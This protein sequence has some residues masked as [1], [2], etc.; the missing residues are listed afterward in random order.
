[1]NLQSLFDVNHQ[2]KIRRICEEVQSLTGIQLGPQKHEMVQGRLSRRLRE[3]RLETLDQ[4]MTLLER[5]PSEKTSLIDILTTNKTSFF[6]EARHFEVL[7]RHL[8][9]TVK[10]GGEPT[11]WSAGCSSGE[12]PYTMAIVARRAS[13]PARILATDISSRV[14]DT[15]RWGRYPRESVGD[16]PE[17]T[18]RSHFVR[19]AEGVEVVP[20]TKALVG[21]ARLN[22]LGSWP[23]RGGFS[24]IF[25]RNVMI[26]FDR[27]T[28]EALARRYYELLAPGGLLFV[29]LSESLNGLDHRFDQVEPG[30]YRK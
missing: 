29:G 10:A 13:I 28:R 8:L 9:Q 5:D 14:L 1:M 26:Y 4:Y 16:L 18:V 25:C 3:L 19:C 7:E 15:A 23:M 2:D 6:R 27:S 17:T 24:A 21:F 30:A 20:D 22:L 12:E 11:V